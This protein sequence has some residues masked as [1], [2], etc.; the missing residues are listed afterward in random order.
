MSKE[1]SIRRAVL[2]QISNRAQLFGL[3]KSELTDSFNLVASGLLDSMSFVELVVTLENEFEVELAHD[4][5]FEKEEFA[6]IGGLVEH[7]KA[8]MEKSGNP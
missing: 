4:S 2:E 1:N 8:A 7:F 6:T 3:S 5:V